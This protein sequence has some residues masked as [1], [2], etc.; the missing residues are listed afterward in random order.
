MNICMRRIH[1]IFITTRSA[2]LLYSERTKG[3]LYFG[4]KVHERTTN[5]FQKSVPSHR[6]WFA[7]TMLFMEHLQEYAVIG[8]QI[9]LG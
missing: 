4:K 6:P 9:T 2:T 1:F 5:I 8:Q 3:Q 7:Q